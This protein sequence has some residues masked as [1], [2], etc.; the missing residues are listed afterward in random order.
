MCKMKI[1]QF[2]NKPKTIFRKETS[3]DLYDIFA[4]SKGK[5]VSF[6]AAKHYPQKLFLILFDINLTFLNLDKR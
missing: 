4:Q 1:F 3:K 5:T 2:F 6:Y